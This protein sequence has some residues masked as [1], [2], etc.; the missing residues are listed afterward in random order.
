MFTDEV[1]ARLLAGSRVLQIG[2]IQRDLADALKRRGYYVLSADLD[3]YDPPARYF[4]AAV[5]QTPLAAELDPVDFLEKTARAL[6]REGFIAIEDRSKRILCALRERF[7]QSVYE[8]QSDG[9]FLFIGSPVSAWPILIGGPERRKIVLAEHN[10]EWRSR[11]EIERRRIVQA[12]GAQARRVE[13]IGSTAVP[14]L[15]AKPIVDVLVVVDDPLDDRI[16]RSLERAGYVLRVEEPQH[17]MFRSPALDVHVHLW[18]TESPEIERH[19]SFRNRLRENPADRSLYERVKR[20][21]AKRD[22]TDQND[23]AQA[24]DAVVWEILSARALRRT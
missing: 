13:H 20:E 15:A 17:R 9:R 3:S 14:G 24:K 23:Y 7:K 2:P 22:W 11:F 12:I 21:L 4:D 18:E 8:P 1:A 6:R 16:R 10:S 5:V 19:L